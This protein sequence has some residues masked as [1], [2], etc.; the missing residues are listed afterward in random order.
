LK[1][2][3]KRSLTGIVLVGLLYGALFAGP[4]TFYLFF[5]LLNV[6]GLWEFYNM[7]KRPEWK[8]QRYVGIVSGL[9]TITVFY[10]AASG[11]V[12]MELLFVLIP[13]IFFVFL[14]ELFRKTSF[15]IVNVGFTLFAILY[16]SV[17][18]SMLSFMAFVPAAGG[19]V[20]DPWIIGA[21]FLLIMIN[22]SAGY[23]VG[24][25]FGKNRLFERIS[26][27]KSWEGAIGGLVFT[28]LTAWLISIYLSE[29]GTIVW[30][31]I[32]LL[33]VIFGTFGDLVESMFK[34]SLNVKDSGNIFPGHGGILDRYDAIFVSAPFV[35][36]YLKLFVW[37]L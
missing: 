14:F 29:P 25:P 34:R 7:V 3:Y 26:P 15:P 27:K 4:L 23:L 10:L 6:I 1:D 9:V 20:Y 11:Q 24:V 35:V 21:Y 30:L 18:I 31:V 19:S 2:L 22:D 32:G 36:A 8:P 28:L 13:V 5:S 37:N 17:P 16:I 12:R 33:V